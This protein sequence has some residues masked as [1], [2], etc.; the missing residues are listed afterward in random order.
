MEIAT[1]ETSPTVLILT[2]LIA[3]LAEI[4]PPHF[5]RDG[6]ARCQNRIISQQPNGHFTLIPG[7][8]FPISA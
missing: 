6:R 5:I 1:V 8:P 7:H 2:G 4:A 3:V